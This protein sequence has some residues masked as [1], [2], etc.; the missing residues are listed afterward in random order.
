MKKIRTIEANEH[1]G[2]QVQLCGWL[3]NLRPMGGVNFLVL[4]DGWG[5]IQAVTENEADLAPVAEL[6][7]ETV[8]ILEGVPVK[9]PQAP[10]GVE[11]HQPQIKVITPIQENPPVPLNKRQIKAGLPVQL[12]HAVVI[13]RHPARRAIF[14]LAAGVMAGFRASLNNMGFTEI[15]T[16]K[17]VASATESG[18]NVFRLGYFGRDAYLAQSPQFYKQMMVGVFERVYEVG[19][20]FRAESHDTSRHNQR[21]C[22]PGCGVWLYR[23]PFYRNGAAARGACRHFCSTGDI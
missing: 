4:R 11:L 20:V 17:I 12:D 16:P 23:K 8:I 7:L 1:I 2:Q 9:T 14:R 10:G 21:I 19:P 22:E 3:H 18:A 13:N 5:T 15:Q 6:N